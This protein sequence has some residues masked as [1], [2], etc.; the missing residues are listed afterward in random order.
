[1]QDDETPYL[2]LKSTL[3]HSRRVKDVRRLIENGFEV[4]YSP[5]NQSQV[6]VMLKGPDNSYYKDGPWLVQVNIPPGYPS[7]APSI[8]FLNRIF[9]PNIDA[10]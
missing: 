8:S 3:G 5:D 1:M 6:A 9:H 10:K 7:I 2:G 4:N